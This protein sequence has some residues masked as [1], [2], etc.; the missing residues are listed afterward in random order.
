MGIA[1]AILALAEAGGAFAARRDSLDMRVGFIGGGVMAEAMLGGALASGLCAPGDAAVGEPIETRR[2]ELTARYGVAA[3]ERNAA[4][5]ES[6]EF[7]VVAVKPQQIGGV[8]ADLRAALRPEQTVLS[9]AAGIP[10]R[11]LADGLGH[12]RIIRA[13]PNT[14][15]QIGAG[16]SVW[17]AT[18]E[19]P[20]DALKSAASLLATLGREIRVESEDYLDIATA[21]SGSGPAYVFAFIEALTEAGALLGMARE[22]ARTLAVET[23]AG[24]AALARESGESPAVLRER[25]TSPGGT[26]AAALRELERGGFRTAVTDAVSAAFRR[27]REL[28]GGA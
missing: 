21:L 10:M 11:A 17:T 19:T 22:T 14:P 7:V 13:M 8:Y 27:A 16:V 6:A 23:T 18:P 4:A 15:A 3:H 20:E 12:S 5:A 2:G 1:S 24:A 28:G 26:T 25:V 9:I